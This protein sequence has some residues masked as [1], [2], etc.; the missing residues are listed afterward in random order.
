MFCQIKTVPLDCFQKESL[1]LDAR[2]VLVSGILVCIPTCNCSRSLPFIQQVF[3]ECF[4][5]GLFLSEDSEQNK[6]PLFLVL[7]EFW[8]GGRQILGK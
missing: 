2:E 1:V 3:T 5:Q 4:C 7:L 6:F 8:M